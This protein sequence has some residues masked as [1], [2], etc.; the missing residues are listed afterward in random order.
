MPDGHADGTDVP[1]G[2][3]GARSEARRHAGAM[4]SGMRRHGK[5]GEAR[6]ARQEA[7]GVIPMT[8]DDAACW[9]FR[10][11]RFA[12]GKRSDLSFRALRFA[13]GKRSEESK[14]VAQDPSRGSG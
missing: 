11:L 14:R 12:Q 8:I 13:Q 7:R 5:R 3:H 9:S 6:G 1:R 2:V 10:A 4:A